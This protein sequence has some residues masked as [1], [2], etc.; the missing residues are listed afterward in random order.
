LDISEQLFV[1][2]CIRKKQIQGIPEK[3]QP[4][5]EEF[6]QFESEDRLILDVPKDWVGLRDGTLLSMLKEFNEAMYVALALFVE[7]NDIDV[8]DVLGEPVDR[9]DT[10]FRGKRCFKYVKKRLRVAK[11]V[12][13]ENNIFQLDGYEIDLK[14]PNPV[15]HVLSVYSGGLSSGICLSDFLK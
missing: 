10:T 13:S 15:I 12:D 11:V 8:T 3:F 1:E 5:V 2:I 14:Y 9:Y 4:I 6:R 7:G